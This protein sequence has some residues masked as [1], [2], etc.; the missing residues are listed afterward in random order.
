MKALYLLKELQLDGRVELGVPMRELTTMRVGGPAD[1]VVYAASVRD[2]EKVSLF[3]ADRG[4]PL[5]VVGRG[6]NLVV[7]DGGLRGVVLVL[8]ADFARIA[9]EGE[10]LTAQA[11]ATLGAIA[12]AAQENGLTGLEF[13]EGIPGSVGGGVYMNAGAYGGEM[14]QVLTW[15]KAL[16]PGGE[17]VQL[18]REE[19][20][21]SYRHTW[22][23]ERGGVVLEACF[24]LKKGDRAEICAR[25]A[26]LRTRR[27][28]KQPLQY[29]SSGSFFKR[30]EGY[31][32]GKLIEDAGL[33]G[34]S[35]GGA[36]ISTQH[37]GFLINT[38][39]ATASDVIQLMH[40][41]Q[42]TVYEKYGVRLE[43]EVRILG[44]E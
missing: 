43:P 40:Q 10:E 33:K 8:G 29:P 39:N 6:S 36:Q 28:E 4:V 24:T 34:A 31:F 17:V 13:A 2:V 19:M 5:Y 21:M 30:P 22:L 25:M 42:Q 16:M 15:V 9:V 26:D 37:A 41:V 1:G 35:V 3:C 11:G 18:S 32:A 23:M 44:E 14:S 27:R 12:R 20:D 7:R 38:G